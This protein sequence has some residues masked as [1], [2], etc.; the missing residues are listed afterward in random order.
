MALAASV[1]AGVPVI[2]TYPT[3]SAN[4]IVADGTTQY[5]VSFKVSDGSGYNHI[6]CMRVLFGYS[7]AGGDSARGRGYL[8]WGTS[9]ATITKYGGVWVLAADAAGVGRWG[10]ITDS[11]GGTTYISPISCSVANSGKAS[12]GTGYRTVTW[13]FTASPAWVANP[14]T[15]DADAWTEDAAGNKLGWCDNPGEFDVV[16][17]ACASQ[18]VLPSAPFVSNP[19]LN[20]A[21]V[22]IAPTDSDSD[23]YCIRISPGYDG[24]DYVQQGGALGLTPFWQTKSQWG[25]TAVSGLVGGMTYSFS[26]RAWNT[27]AGVCPSVFGSAA[28][29]TT[30]IESRAIDATAAGVPMHRG[31]IGNATRLDSGVAI[32]GKTWDILYD[33]CARGIA[34]GLD[35]D[36]Y[37]WKDMSG[38]GVGHTGVPGADV[39]TTLEWMR[40]VRD[41][42]S[43]PL[44]TANVRGIGPVASSGYNTFYYTDTSVAA[45]KALAADW[46]RYINFIL[47]TYRQ[48]DTLPPSDQ[49]IVDSINWYGKPKLLEPGE[50]A[51]PKVIYW[52]IGN[53]P[54]VPLPWSTPGAT[55]LSLDGPGYAARYREFAQAMLA[56][57][58]AIK[59]GPCVLTP[60]PTT[61]TLDAVLSDQ[62]LPVDFISHHPYG[63]LEWFGNT[64]GDT[65]AS[66]EAGLRYTK[67]QLQGVHANVIAAINRCG[68]SP[69][70]IP[71]I[72]SEYNPSNWKWECKAQIRRVAHALGLADTLFTFTE[73]GL[74][75]ANYWSWPAWCQDGTETPGYKLFEMAQQHWGQSLIDSYS[76]GLNFRMY[77]TWNPSAQD[78]CVWAVNFSRNYDKPMSIALN[79]LGTVGSVTQKRLQNLAG[80]TGLLDSNSPP[81]TTPP[82]VDWTTSDLTGT[83]V[84]SGFS[85]TFA[86]ATVTLLVFHRALSLVEIRNRQSGDLVG[87][88]SAPVS[89]VFDGF[90]YIQAEDR[91]CGMRVVG[92]TTG[93]SVGSRVSVSGVLETNA[94]GERQIRADCVTPVGSL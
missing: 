63:P 52:E 31:V 34:G 79:G 74:L 50:A 71:I 78:L 17:S 83:L 58:P 57:D 75:A 6:I 4:P 85:A 56:V 9:D 61:A 80:T 43:T 90:F 2:A 30:P 72:A 47:P 27:A 67:P 41:H 28:T 69:A 66:A 11:W 26:A 70:S 91:S 53:E 94:H 22:A 84:P 39:Q 16:G 13:T 77:T 40:A 65:A 73:Q 8:A 25:T 86:R 19:T 12:G 55:Q 21:D 45:V 23:I 15:N 88:A 89:G 42:R 32:K 76:D 59:L 18:A 64:Y 48:G 49:A 33:T 68:R 35:A 93:L 20:T 81:P 29:A 60:N 54:E 44:V 36:T 3:V 92:S 5:T 37:N 62:T 7:E 14:L 51:T 87:V 38:Q 24:N 1:N 82:V 46:V 10:Y